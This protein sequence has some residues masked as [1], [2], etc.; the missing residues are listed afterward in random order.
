VQRRPG[1]LLPRCVQ[2]SRFRFWSLCLSS[3]RHGRRLPGSTATAARTVLA[4]STHWRPSSDPS[5]S[6]AAEFCS[7]AKAAPGARCQSSIAYPI[8]HARAIS[9]HGLS[10][11][12]LSCFC[13]LAG[14]HRLRRPPTG[15]DST[16]TGR[17]PQGG[18]GTGGHQEIYCAYSNAQVQEFRTKAHPEAASLLAA[19]TSR[20]LYVWHA[21][22]GLQQ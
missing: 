17:A 19:H 14:E 9:R 22:A 16:F 13:A 7:Q 6:A 11:F 4:A 1:P 18:F 15:F 12:R 8:S 3:V 2:I 10:I 5:F 20:R 21:G